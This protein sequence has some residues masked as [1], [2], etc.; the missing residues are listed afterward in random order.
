MGGGG[1]S[2]NMCVYSPLLLNRLEICADFC[3]FFLGGDALEC[4]YPMCLWHIPTSTP[5]G[6]SIRRDH[7]FETGASGPKLIAIA[8]CNIVQRHYLC[9]PMW[10]TVNNDNG[11]TMQ[12]HAATSCSFCKS[13]P[14]VDFDESIGSIAGTMLLL[15]STFNSNVIKLST[16][17][18]FSF[19]HIGPK[20]HALN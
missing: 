19:Q 18:H 15:V 9:L 13:F 6:I 7:Y 12:P 20:P 10:A 16:I 5:K 2:T 3:I 14:C 8:N 1:R 17:S 4:S 11:M